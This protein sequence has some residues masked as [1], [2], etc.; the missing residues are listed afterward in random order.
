MALSIYQTLLS[1]RVKNTDAT[2]T[3]VPEFPWFFLAPEDTLVFV[4]ICMELE[5]S[6]EGISAFLLVGR[7]RELV[8]GPLTKMK[9]L[10]EAPACEIRFTLGGLRKSSEGK[11]KAA[12]SAEGMEKSREISLSNL[13][14]T[15]AF[16]SFF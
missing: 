9:G 16:M 11:K 8:A 1:F 12:A 14:L 7:Q 2:K 6:E 15:C 4:E 5:V 3:A 10:P 13:T